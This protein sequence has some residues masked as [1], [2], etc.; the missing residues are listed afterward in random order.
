MSEK[1]EE[2]N[3]LIDFFKYGILQ[4]A[5]SMRALVIVGGFSAGVMNR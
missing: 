2:D 1:K 5:V 4:A 3:L